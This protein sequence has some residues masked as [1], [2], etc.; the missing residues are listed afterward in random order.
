MNVLIDP[1]AHPVIAHR[2]DSAH[3]PEN[4]FAAF[5]QAVALG[6]DALELDVRLTRD[7]VPVVIHD[8]TVD[9]TTDGRGAVDSHTLAELQRLDAGARYTPD[10]GRT[11]PYRGAG[12]CVPLLQ[13]LVERYR[14]LPLLIE[15]KLPSA[16]EPTRRVLDQC[17]AV[18]RTLVDSMVHAAV[19]PFRGNGGATETVIATGASVDDVLRLIRRLWRTASLPYKA[20]C[21]PRWYRGL[22]VPVV[23]LSR[24]AKRAGV[25]TH[26]WTVNAPSVAR[27][28]W[29][30]GVQGII[31]DDPGP[32]VR[33]RAEVFGAAERR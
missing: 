25:V 30:A 12:V 6:A 2:G 28:L 8:E 26:V 14:E 9:R 22:R 23:V 13:E 7:G 29:Q 15:L 32:M 24:A 27:R 3:A 1:A 31:T 17:N 16:A 20:L 33:V 19:E 11:F 21:V 18:P 4:T 5:D 10:G